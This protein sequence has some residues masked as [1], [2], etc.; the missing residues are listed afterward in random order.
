MVLESVGHGKIGYYL[1]PNLQN[2]HFFEGLDQANP[3]RIRSYSDFKIKML[4]ALKNKN[5]QINND[6][7]NFFC[8]KSDK[9]SERIFN[10]LNNL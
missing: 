5:Y 6:D 2:D 1:D 4:D 10:F 9:V 8:L 3:I 7:R